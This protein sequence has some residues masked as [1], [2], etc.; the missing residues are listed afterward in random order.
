MAIIKSREFWLHPIGVTEALESS[1]TSVAPTI[2]VAGIA[3]RSVRPRSLNSAFICIDT[4]E[5]RRLEKR[6]SSAKNSKKKN[7]Q[8]KILYAKAEEKCKKLSETNSSLGFEIHQLEGKIRILEHNLETLLKNINDRELLIRSAIGNN[9]EKSSG[10]AKL[11]ER[12]GVGL[13]LQGGLPGLGKK[14][15]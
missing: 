1:I 2:R 14:S 15:R 6:L 12:G 5:A 7:T 3:S 10:L 11:V 13:P 4:D 9:N 8:V